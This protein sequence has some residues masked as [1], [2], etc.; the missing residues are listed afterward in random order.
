[1]KTSIQGGKSLGKVIK[2]DVNQVGLS[3]CD[4]AKMVMVQRFEEFH[5]G[6]LPLEV[7]EEVFHLAFVSGNFKLKQLECYLKYFPV[8]DLSLCAN[9]PGHEAFLPCV[10]DEWLEVISKF[11]SIQSLSIFFVFLCVFCPLQ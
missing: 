5:L 9:Y 2:L 1:M 3:L 4:Q 8:R 7:A 11:S 6:L 10:T